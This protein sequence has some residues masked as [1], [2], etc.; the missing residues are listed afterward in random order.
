ME[1][2]V[3]TSSKTAEVIARYLRSKENFACIGVFYW[4]TRRK[5]KNLD[6]ACL[7]RERTRNKTWLTR[8]RSAIR[9]IGFL[10]AAA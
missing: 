5:T 7:G 9:Y 6:V 4:C 8:D 10:V 2:C 1:S 3:C